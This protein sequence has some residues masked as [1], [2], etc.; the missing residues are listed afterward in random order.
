M[1]LLLLLLLLL[2]WLLPPATYCWLRDDLGILRLD[3]AFIGV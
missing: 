2:L 1:I 3:I